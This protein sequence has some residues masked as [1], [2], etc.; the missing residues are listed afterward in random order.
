MAIYDQ[1]PILL[2]Y[3]KNNYK[4]V[5][6]YLTSDDLWFPPGGIK[7]DFGDNEY[8]F[9]SQEKINE[10]LSE[11]RNN[12]LINIL[13][14]K[15]INQKKIFDWKVGDV[16]IFDYEVSFISDM[17]DNIICGTTDEY[18]GTT[19]YDLN[20]RCF[21]LNKVNYRVSSVVNRLIKELYSLYESSELHEFYLFNYPY[22]RDIYID[23]W[24]N[25]LNSGKEDLTKIHDFINFIT[26]AINE[27]DLDAKLDNG[28]KLFRERSI[29]LT[30]NNNEEELI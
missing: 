9:V 4:I 22:I 10:I 11:Y 14:D 19:G 21:E 15:N 23:I 13:E 24:I 12:N 3:T 1:I 28:E 2:G 29:N 8:H 7:I 27:G 16:I 25:V 26:H 18:G 30:E 6:D 20:N 17:I 5:T